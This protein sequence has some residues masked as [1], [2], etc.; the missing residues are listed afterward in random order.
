MCSVSLSTHKLFP[1]PLELAGRRESMRHH[2]FLGLAAAS[3]MIAVAAVSS[4]KGQR[5]LVLDWAS[6]IPAEAP[7]VAVLIDL[8][9]TDDRPTSWSGQVEVQ[10]AT[11]VHREGYRFRA[12]D[13]LGGDTSWVASSHRP[14]ALPLRN[15]ALARMEGIVSVGIVLH[16]AD[17]QPGATLTLTIPQR[18]PAKEVVPLQDVLAGRARRMWDGA[19][20]VRR[21][22][23]ALPIVTARTEDDF[24]AAAYGPDGTL[25]LAYISYT[26]RDESRRIA[27]PPFEKQPA[28]FLALYTPE[29][30]DQ[31]FVKYYRDGKWSK[32][33]AVTGPRE[34]LM[35]CAVAVAGDGDAWVVYSAHRH[36]RYEVYAR[37]ISKQYSPAGTANPAPGLGPEQLLTKG[38]VANLTPVLA[39]DQE[40]TLHLAYQAWEQGGK[41]LLRRLRCQKGEWTADPERNEARPPEAALGLSGNNWSAALATG[42]GGE[43]ALAGDEYRKGDFDVGLQ[44]TDSKGVMSFSAAQSPKFEAR[45][46]V[47]YDPQGRLWIAYEEG[48]EKWGK[49]Y[50][51]LD[52]EDGNPL[53]NARSVRVLCYQNGQLFRPVAELPTSVATD[54]HP[55]ERTL[56]YAYPRIGIDGKGRLWLTYRQ[57]FGTRYSTHLGSFWLT[58]A[59]RLD[60]EHWTEPVELHHSDG[61][62]DSRPVL[63]P[64]AAGGLLV[65]HNTDGRWTTP[66]IIDNQ[67]YQSYVDLPGEPVEP[68]LVPHQPESKTAQAVQQAE[69][70]RAAVQR[71]RAYRIEAGGKKYQLL[72]G[73]FH[74]H[75]EVSWDGGPDGSLEDMFRYALDVAA[76]DWIG[77]TDHDNGGGREYTWWLTQ[78][79]TDAYHV[80]Q[81]F[82][83]VFAYER[84]VSYP[85][86]HRNCIF[87]RRGVRT[88][89]RLAEADPAKRVAGVHADDTK[90]LYRYLHELDG[91]C[92]SHTS[93]TTMG[94]DWR[95]NDPQV[96]PVVE[97]YQGD[98]MSYEYQEAPRAGHDPRS[99]KKPINI[100]GWEPAGFINL[101]LKNGYRLGFESSSDHWSTHI[102]YT[103]VLAERHDREAIVEALKKRHCYAATD[104]IIADL[105]SGDHLMGDEFRTSQPPT[106]QMT[107][108]GTKPL[109]RVDIL[110]DS[111]VVHTIEP[112]RP[113]Y[114]GSWTDP[115][116]E[117]GLHYYY[118]RVQQTGGELAWTSPLWIESS[119][120]R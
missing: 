82:T 68:R 60:G 89:P 9:L 120:G 7:P 32:P 93:A 66:E 79:L 11:V 103:I 2:T 73:E 56:R 117:A 12:G 100:G 24:P 36:G 99:G 59:R 88:L 48:P 40:G 34:D 78:K 106:L 69:E 86:G 62:L 5:L 118:V 52:A 6:K 80:P 108:I 87:S 20:A 51:A 15:P 97:I 65:V 109:A 10:G 96:E 111:A 39:T 21:I 72:R 107:F 54:H 85:H 22:S 18:R 67:I 49:D 33:L 110:K 104:D 42:P 26:L 113:Q 77:N 14:I 114:Q 19:V 115:K 98:R 3:F 102:S 38:G 81:S 23:T 47:C 50:G 64:H 95:D 45:P 55:D 101:A 4:P 35:R 75:T 119:R 30:A 58:F 57:K 71:M 105:R 27:Q 16:L 83:P 76:L 31:L 116:P 112:R 46:S 94:T 92:A 74:R 25:W 8:G 70:E 37:P 53:Y 84:S 63:L 41:A 29:F 61:L 1:V 44:V 28:D 17:V 43:V 13:H 91:I 90:M